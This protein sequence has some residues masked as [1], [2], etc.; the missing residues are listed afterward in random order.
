M[1]L[2]S[3]Y[4]ITKTVSNGVVGSRDQNIDTQLF[5]RIDKGFY[6]PYSI[7]DR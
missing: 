2:I 4:L 6:K 7:Y 5:T 3:V 1:R